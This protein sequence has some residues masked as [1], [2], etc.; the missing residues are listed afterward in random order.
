MCGINAVINGTFEQVKAMELAT[1]KRGVKS[2]I[3]H[4]KNAIVSFNLLPITDE[5]RDYGRVVYEDV[6][7]FCNGFISNHK[8]L[9]KKYGFETKTSCDTEVL[10]MFLHHFNGQRLNELNGFFSVLYWSDS[11]GYWSAFTDRYGAKQLY[12]YK[13]VKGTEFISS[14][15]KGLL[16]VCPEIK[17]DSFG[18]EDWKTTLGVMNPDTIYFGVKR[19]EKLPF[20]VPEKIKISYKDAKNQLVGLLLQAFERNKY[21]GSDGAF[22]SGGIDSGII[23]KWL[24]P[25]FTFSMDYSDEKFSESEL[26]KKNSIGVHYSMICNKKLAEIYAHKTM[27]ALDDL[28]AGSC[29]TNFALAE[30]AS[31]FVKVI[32]SGAGG[33]EFFG[34]YPHRKRNPIQNSVCRTDYGIEFYTEKNL[35]DWKNQT[36]FEYDL[37]FLDAVLVVEDR[38]SGFHTM[39]T[40]Y[41]LLD[42][43]LVDFALSLPD[44]YTENKRILKDV[45]SLHPD[46]INGKKKGFSNPFFTNDEWVNFTLKNLKR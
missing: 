32:Y 1:E 45:S 4:H 19:V 34:G 37:K 11:N 20:V 26:I 23:A 5:T 43:D 46:V 3:T 14:E 30:L 22:L 18:I 33:D 40:R 2:F 17:F 42:N 9:A 15:V 12:S 36:H 24:N 31:K 44:E 35:E 41:P 27:Y 16:A 29:Y 25:E 21:G 38:M 39:E 13:D 28:K 7:V 10:A 6:V 8:E